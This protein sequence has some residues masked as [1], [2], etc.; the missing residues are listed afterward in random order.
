MTGSQL[1]AV[2]RDVARVAAFNNTSVLLIGAWAR[3][4][5]L[6]FDSPS[7]GTTD[8]DLAL[9]FENWSS[10]DAFLA[11][12]ADAFTRIDHRELTMAH[13]LTGMRGDI[14]PCG[15][16]ESPPGTLSL[17]GSVRRLNTL[18]V[19]ECFA[20]GRPLDAQLANILIPPPD[21]MLVLK[22]L[23]FVDRRAPR[24]LR[25][26]GHVLRRFPIDED[27][28]WEDPRLMQAFADGSLSL[29]DA[30]VWFAG[31]SIATRFEATTVTATREAVRAVAHDRADVRLGL[32]D[33]ERTML[34]DARR[35][36][37]DRML[38][39]WIRALSP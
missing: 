38:D 29:D 17:R 36:L 34:A 32:V 9:Q 5:C 23:A 8:V 16:L 22:L 12:C 11:R 39:T 14:V 24:D 4:L 25:D 33:E 3:D 27:A 1:L 15:G 30:R 2:A 20:L 21:G 35:R 6:G 37:A 10:V 18:G 31:R 19:K 13:R 7:R 26:V 28:I